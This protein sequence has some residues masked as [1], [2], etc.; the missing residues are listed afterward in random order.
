MYDIEKANEQMETTDVPIMT[1]SIDDEFK[2]NLNVLEDE[3][4]KGNRRA[5][6]TCDDCDIPFNTKKELRV[7]ITAVWHNFKS[8]SLF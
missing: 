6:T 7:S 4:S 3:N 1:D 5:L 2:P 8:P